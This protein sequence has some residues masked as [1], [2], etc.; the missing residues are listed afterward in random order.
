MTGFPER[1]RMGRMSAVTRVLIL[2]FTAIF[3]AMAGFVVGTL[4]GIAL[5]VTVR[6]AGGGF[7]LTLAYLGAAIGFGLGTIWVGRHFARHG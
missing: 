3:G 1:D 2:L 7:T 5:D 6:P 4:I